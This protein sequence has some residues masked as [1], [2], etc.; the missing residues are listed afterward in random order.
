VNGPWLQFLGVALTA[1]V[2]F[3]IAAGGWIAA[4]GSRKA[5]PYDVL[6]RRVVKL[7]DRLE[8]VESEN[9]SLRKGRAE[10]Q[11][12]ITGL[13]R[14]VDAVMNDRDRLVAYV[15]VM[16]SWIANGARPPAPTLPTHLADVVPA[17]V[18]GDDA[19]RPRPHQEVTD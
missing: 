13:Q 5:S 10:D 19:E 9:D 16:Q 1:M 8:H 4:R 3:A 11:T 2:M 7:E 6:E 17:W 14:R 12:K 15:K 18:P